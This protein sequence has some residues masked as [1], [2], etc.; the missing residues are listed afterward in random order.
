MVEMLLVIAV[1]ITMMGIAIPTFTNAMY[2]YRQGA[3]VAGVQ[4]AL[5]STRFLAIMKGYS[6]Q[7]VFT[8]ST[9]TYQIYN[10]V[11]PATTYSLVVPATGSSTTPLPNAGKVTMTS[12]GCS[13]ALTNWACTPT[14]DQTANSG[15]TITYT[16][17]ANG[18]VTSSPASAGI[19]ISNSVKSNTIWISGVG[20]VGTS[21]P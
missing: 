13:V 10:E 3:S 6:Y 1:S 14:S 11:P 21:S 15:T 19:Q 12:V 7:L 8:P 4:A 9:M 16:F 2:S 5:S 18:T 20:D 17:L